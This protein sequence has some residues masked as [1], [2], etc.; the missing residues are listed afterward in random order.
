MK[1]ISYYRYIFGRFLRMTRNKQTAED[2]TQE[3][4]LHAW[5]NLHKSR[6]LYPSMTFINMLVNHM[7]TA[8]T[9]PNRAVKRKGIVLPLHEYVG[10]F[11]YSQPYEERI[12]TKELLQIIQALPE[13]KL[14]VAILYLLEKGFLSKGEARYWEIIKYNEPMLK[15]LVS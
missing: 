15:G 4:F 10:V 2:Y 1:L 11:A 3:L 5:K 9:L 8:L 14:K 13:S 12:L 7:Y 6:T